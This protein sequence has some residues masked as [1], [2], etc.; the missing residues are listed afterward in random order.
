MVRPLLLAGLALLA[1]C[2]TPEP[3]APAPAGAAEPVVLRVDTA[4]IAEADPE[5]RYAA[6]LAY[7]Q[8]APAEGG[9]LARVNRAIEDTARAFVAAVRPSRDDLSGNP[10]M[11]R[12][13]V[14]EIEGGFGPILLQDDLFSTLLTAYVYS[15]GAHGNTVARPL[16]F[17]LRTGQPIVL[18][19]LFRSTSAYLDTLATLAT[20]RL[21]EE[22]GETDW[23]FDGAIPPIPSAF[24]AF[25]LRPDSL[26][27]YFPPYSI[28]AYAF[29]PSEVRLAYDELGGV[30]DP[31]G[32]VSRLR[33]A[34]PVAGR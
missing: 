34:V 14:G 10:E 4:R 8:L 30:L 29:G 33:R 3:D 23:L 25:A 17:D 9:A 16:T 7:P 2:A 32:P 15:G 20:D 13:I 12:W 5:L 18:R 27:L 22:R 1:A 21:S 24:T 19:D 11:D 31:N 6:A 26:L 28:A